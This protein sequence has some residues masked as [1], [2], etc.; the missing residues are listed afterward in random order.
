M[1]ELAEGVPRILEGAPSDEFAVTR[2]EVSGSRV[3][4]SAQ[5]P[6]P[7]FRTMSYWRN[8]VR[9]WEMRNYEGVKK[10]GWH[11]G[12]DWENDPHPADMVVLT[13][14]A[15]MTPT[16]MIEGRW[17]TWSYADLMHPET[18]SEI[19]W[20]DSVNQKCLTVDQKQFR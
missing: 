19:L 12:I 2:D 13:Q 18:F 4:T 6:K 9:A 11:G 3:G 1:T 16:M 20:K 8:L 15:T 17:D 5:P 7:P 14:G 10:R